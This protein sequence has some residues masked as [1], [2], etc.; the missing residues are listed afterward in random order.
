MYQGARGDVRTPEKVLLQ[1]WFV[2]SAVAVDAGVYAL[3]AVV[4]CWHLLEDCLHGDYELCGG[5]SSSR[6]YL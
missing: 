1:S 5:S 6:S 3:T 2:A 4:S